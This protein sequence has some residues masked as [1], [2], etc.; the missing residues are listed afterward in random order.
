MSKS[1]DESIISNE[2][3]E[4]I[5]EKIAEIKKIEKEKI[6]I[7][8]NLINDLFFDSLDLAEIKASIQGNFE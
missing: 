4:K 1:I 7:K 6:S 8:S 2:T 5:I 3:K